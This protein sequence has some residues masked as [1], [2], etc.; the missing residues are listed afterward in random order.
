MNLRSSLVFKLYKVLAPCINILYLLWKVERKSHFIAFSLRYDSN[1]FI[2]FFTE[3]YPS[4]S[5]RLRINSV[6]DENIETTTTN[7]STLPGSMPSSSSGILSKR[8]SSRIANSKPY[9]RETITISSSEDEV[10]LGFRRIDWGASLSKK[11]LITCL[12][13]NEW[14]GWV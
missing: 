2:I 12:F 3:N 6:I 4:K 14:K 13:F 11:E 9:K 8:R 1:S 10:G 7:A 5:K